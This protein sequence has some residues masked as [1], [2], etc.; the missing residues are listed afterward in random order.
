MDVSSDFASRARIWRS[1]ISKPV[2]TRY[3]VQVRVRYH[4]AAFLNFCGYPPIRCRP[5]QIVLEE[6]ILHTGPTTDDHW[7]FILS[8]LGRYFKQP[9]SIDVSFFFTPQNINKPNP[10]VTTPTTEK[11]WKEAEFL[12]TTTTCNLCIMKEQIM[13]ILSVTKSAYQFISF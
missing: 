13:R 6:L 3:Q 11:Y 4:A 1:H 5:P 12:I 2:P 7:F 9:S 8:V 10:P